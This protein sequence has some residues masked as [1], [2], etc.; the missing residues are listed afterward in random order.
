[1][2]C[3]RVLC[4]CG[5]TFPRRLWPLGHSPSTTVTSWWCLNRGQEAFKWRNPKNPEELPP[6]FLT[7]LTKRCFSATHFCGQSKY[8]ELDIQCFQN[9]CQIYNMCP[10]QQGGGHLEQTLGCIS[11]DIGAE[12]FKVSWCSVVY[13]HHQPK[14]ISRLNSSDLY[15]K[16]SSSSGE[17]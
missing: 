12:R 15:S 16:Y 6:L 9:G 14:T 13:I 10:F 17:F 11:I 7:F 2:S 1:M 5:K 8:L 3:R 4:L